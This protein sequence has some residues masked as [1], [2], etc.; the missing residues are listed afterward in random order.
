LFSS[1]FYAPIEFFGRLTGSLGLSVILFTVLSKIVLFPISLISQKNSIVMVKLMPEIDDLKQRYESDPSALL[2]EQKILYKREHYSSIKAVLPL[3]IQIPIIIGVIGAVNRACANIDAFDFGFLGLD[4]SLVPSFSSKLILIPILAV[5]SAVVM[6]VV[7]NVYNVVSREQ[8]FFGKWGITIFLAAFSGYFAFVCTAG[9]GLYWIAGNVLSIVVTFLCNLVYN[10]KKYIDYENRSIRPKLTREEKTAA[11][12][13]KRVAK[14]REN[15]DV[16]RFFSID[17]KRL[18]FYSEASGFY[19]YFQPFIE[20]ILD[21]S[22]IDI[23]YVTSDTNDQVFGI[24]R[25]HFHTFY[26]GPMGFITLA[27]KLDSDIAVMTLPDLDKYH[28]KRSIVKKDIDYIYIDHGMGSYHLC[29]REGALDR[30]DTIFCY[31]KN[32]NEEV[33]ATEKYYGLPE[34]KLVNVGFPLIDKLTEDYKKIQNVKNEKPQIL[35]A[36]SWQKDN[37][38]ELCLQEIIRSLS[39]NG[40]EITFRPHP[41]FVKRFAGKMKQITEFCAQ[42]DDVT[43]QTDFSSNSTVYTSDVVITDWSSIG[44]EFS[45]ATKKPTVFV[46]TPIKVMNPNYKKIGIEPMELWSRSKVGESIDVDKVSEINLLIETL[47]ANPQKYKSQIEDILT[48]H[49]YNLGNTARVGGEYII[50]KVNEKNAESQD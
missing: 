33:R 45:L 38:G 13:Q 44:L 14:L 35:I 6:C 22:D 31:G 9:V 39:G 25:E 43:V 28:I 4:L 18:V 34:K 17:N 42:F 30:F 40:Y 29:L 2:R 19:K 23:Y 8:G 20:Y 5:L 50:A 36:P 27:M 11:K 21:N 1:I 12:Q 7:Q 16:K 41:E 49:M 10:P 15:E 3:L 26:C 24:A 37:L 47:L 46:N 32:H 48:N